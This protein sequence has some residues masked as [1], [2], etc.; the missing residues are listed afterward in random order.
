MSWQTV[1]Y[2][3]ESVKRTRVKKVACT[4]CGKKMRRQLTVDQTINP[5][6]KN[7]DGEP[8]TRGEI[9]EEL[10]AQL[11]A[12]ETEPEEHEKCRS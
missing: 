10:G 9:W 7:S 1:H 8:K 6:N 4:V 2:R 5:F 12:W 3:F 11:D